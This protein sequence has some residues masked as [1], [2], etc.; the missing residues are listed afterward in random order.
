MA[1][2]DPND[3]DRVIPPGRAGGPEDPV[4]YPASQDR[5]VNAGG[6]PDDAHRRAAFGRR[7]SDVPMTYERRRS[8]LPYVI[9]ALLL[10]ALIP[11]VGRVR[12]G[13]EA[14][15]R[16]GDTTIASGGEVGR[17]VGAPAGAKQRFAEWAAEGG[18]NPLPQ[19]SEEN[20]PYTSQGIRLLADAITEASQGLKVADVRQ[21][22]DELRT[23]AD[24]LQSSPGDD[25]HAEYAHAAFLSATKLIGELHEAK[26][27]AAGDTK[28]LAAAAGA[29]NPAAA[30]SPQGEQVRKFFRLAAKAMP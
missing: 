20:H 13:D 23:Q 16:W 22:T 7:P 9:G 30:L 3:R 6:T 10:V 5:R 25:K 28:E 21:R 18:S 1:S 11:L 2:Q 24:R 12:G 14:A 8:I 4:V 19:E 17:D 15:P 26:Q 29:I 27:S